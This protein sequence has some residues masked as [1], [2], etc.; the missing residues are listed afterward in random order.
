MVAHALHL[1][2][3]EPYDDE[4]HSYAESREAQERD[5][6]LFEALI[7]LQCRHPAGGVAAPQV[8][9]KCDGC[10]DCRHGDEPVDKSGVVLVVAWHPR[11]VGVSRPYLIGYVGSTEPVGHAGHC[12]YG[13]AVVVAVVEV[14]R[15]VVAYDS[16]A[17]GIGERSFE[18]VA[19]AEHGA[20]LCPRYEYEQS[21]VV[22]SLA[23][24]P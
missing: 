1:A 4:R 11:V 14:R 8:Y 23:D 20:P 13:A 12:C 19:G 22:V 18:S 9:Y 15:H 17:D 5:A 2:V 3:E 16:A 6:R 24:A 10:H 21:V 7:A